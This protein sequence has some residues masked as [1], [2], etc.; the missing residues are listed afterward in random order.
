[1]TELEKIF[2]QFGGLKELKKIAIDSRKVEPNTLFLAVQGQ[3]AHGENFIDNAIANGAV[4]VVL[5]TTDPNLHLQLNPNCAVPSCYYYQLRKLVSSLAG[6][7]YGD[8]S[9]KL[10]LIGVTGTNGKTTIT[11][12]LAQWANLLGEKSAVMGTNGNGFLTNLQASENTTGSPIVIQNM[13][14]EFVAE[15][16]TFCAI[17][18]SSHGLHQHRVSGLEFKVVV[19]SNLSRDHL[20]YHANLQEYAQA[21]RRLFTDFS[22]AKQIINADDSVGASWI[23]EFPQAVEVSLN[24]A[25]EPRNSQWLKSTAI[26][27]HSQ[28]ARIEFCSSWGNGVLNSSLIGQFNVV[29][30]LLAMATMLSLGYDLNQL[31][32]MVSQLQGVCGRMEMF[33]AKNISGVTKT[34]LA[35][36]I[37][38]YAHTPDALEKALQASL[39]HCE[40]ELWCVV[41]CGGDRDVGK[42]PLMGKIACELAQHVVFTDDN[43]RTENPED[44]MADI[45]AGVSDYA[46]WQVIHNRRTAIEFALTNAKGNDVILV[47]GKGHENYQIIGQEY[48]YFS[49]Q[50]VIQ[51]FQG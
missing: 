41:G 42:R 17:E 25:Y 26:S 46:N 10:S 45:V 9:K 39:L 27:Y 35:T 7:L 2:A 40:G 5:E 44:I 23:A 22:G 20:D 51:K 28:G 16:A 29:N 13:L 19:F 1:M 32:T 48:L 21:K 30:L 14:K 18:V 3:K 43:P 38:D 11:Q 31:T 50:E 33:G 34:H 37:V 4:A 49:D 12:L 24:P 15:N 47:A 8:P 6:E 36:A